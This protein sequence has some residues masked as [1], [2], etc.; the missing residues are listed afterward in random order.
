MI[1]KSTP[2]P[3]VPA[4]QRIYAI[5][6][7][8]GR[9]DLLDRLLRMIRLDSEEREP[10]ARQT[11]IFL[12]DYIDRGPDSRAVIDRLLTGVPGGFECIHLK[13]NHED[14]LL[15]S[16]TD[17]GMLPMWMGNGGTETLLSYGVLNMESPATALK[18][19]YLGSALEKALPDRHLAFFQG[20]ALSAGF[21]DYH[22]VHAGVKP[23]VPLAK[24]AEYDCL[25]IREP[26]LS[27]RGSF[28]KVIVHG[29]TPVAEPE[30]R[31]N[32][33]GIDT[34]GFFTGHLTALRLEGEYRSFLAT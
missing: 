21:G 33:I 24:Q 2:R 14:I 5:G 29:H 1:W 10:L 4:G 32:R 31:A 23:G 26:F 6:D 28:G 8:H 3:A 18:P 15:R 20:L 30:V 7:I 19:Q 22:F 25:Y 13:G 9:L 12:G 27:H 16:L 17:P 11:I 34:G